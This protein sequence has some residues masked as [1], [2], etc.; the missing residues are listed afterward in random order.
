MMD[1]SEPVQF[2]E[3]GPGV[4]IER[5]ANGAVAEARIDLADLPKHDFE[6][7]APAEFDNQTGV[8][9]VTSFRSWNDVATWSAELYRTPPGDPTAVE[10]AQRFAAQSAIAPELAAIAYVQERIRYVSTSFGAGG[11]RPRPPSVTAKRR[12]GDCKDKALL[13]AE[14]LRA[15]G[16]DAGIALV[17]TMR[18]RGPLSAPPS[19]IAF[20]HVVVRAAIRGETYW[21]D[22]T[23]AGQRGPLEFRGRPHSMAA[24]L[25]RRDAEAPIIIPPLP[26]SLVGDRSEGSIDMRA[27]IGRHVMLDGE[28]L[29]VGIDA[30]DLRRN[31]AINGVQGLQQMFEDAHSQEHGETAYEIFDVKDDEASNTIVIRSR[32]RLADPWRQT[33]DGGASFRTTLCYATNLL[34]MVP[35]NGRTLPLS[36][37]QHPLHHVHNETILLPKGRRPAGFRSERMRC[38]N[39]AFECTRSQ[40]VSGDRVRVEVETRTLAPYLPADQALGALRDQTALQESHVLQLRFRAN[41]IAALLSMLQRSRPANLP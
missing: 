19:P 18:P 35:M 15:L 22:A 29:A 20:N 9:T 16:H 21:I 11:Y 2:C 12:Y 26:Q 33:A 17:D 37:L 41:P 1:A 5:R 36:L 8:S 25:L 4:P 27:G 7:W 24:L 6:Y 32:L 13:L 3:R 40:T 31:I 38:A 28:S 39:A 30:E 34:P 10:L 14:I 23:T